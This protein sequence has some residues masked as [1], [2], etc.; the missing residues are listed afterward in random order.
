VDGRITEADVRTDEVRQLIARHLT[1][2]GGATPP[3]F[4]F[5][6]DHDELIEPGVTLFS[7]RVNDE[8][9]AIGALKHLDDTH[10]ELKSMHTAEE[11]RGR[12]LGRRMLEHL[13]A[14]ARRRGYGRVSLETG[15]TEK[16]APARALYASS[17]FV[18]CPP[19]A[20]YRASDWNTFMTLDLQAPP[21]AQSAQRS[22]M[23][24]GIDAVNIV[25]GENREGR[26]DV[27]RA[28][29]SSAMAMFV[30]DLAPGQASCPYHYE[31]E[32]EWLLVVEGSVTVRR[33]GGE[34]VLQRGD[35]VCFAAGPDGAHKIMNRGDAPAR[36]LLFSV[37]RAPAVSVYPD[38]D[39]IGVFPADNENDLFFRRGT[40]VRYD[41]GEDGW[42]R[43]D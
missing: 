13:V 4:A 8:L 3:D 26:I 33:P 6:L 31:Y 34:Q 43:A 42:E 9:L 32:E 21:Q 20:D 27:A 5:A 22:T 7:L 16:F 37:A 41:D 23:H 18:P 36:T 39:K 29:G 28:L 35:L 2:T 25:T 17:G 14:T 30:Y 40:A 24:P 1:F 10:A 38:S 11:A 19:F 15:S 12:G